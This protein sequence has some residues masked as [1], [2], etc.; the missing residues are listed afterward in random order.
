VVGLKNRRTGS[1]GVSGEC[2][3]GVLVPLTRSRATAA[4]AHM[5][6]KFVMRSIVDDTVV[7]ASCCVGWRSN[8]LFSAEAD[9]AEPASGG[10]YNRGGEGQ[11]C[12]FQHAAS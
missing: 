9:R 4:A 6:G 2:R 5:L 12:T 10:R 8:A 11:L 1:W 7:A 3:V